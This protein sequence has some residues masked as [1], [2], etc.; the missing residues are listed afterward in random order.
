MLILVVV[1]VVVFQWL[2]FS[3]G[4][5]GDGVFSWVLVVLLLRCL[6]N[7]RSGE[8]CDSKIV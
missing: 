1:F 2:C 7:S 4:V 6:S 3:G 5:F 8:K